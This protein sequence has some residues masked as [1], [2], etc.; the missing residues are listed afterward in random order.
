MEGYKW[1][2]GRIKERL[3]D[4]RRRGEKEIGVQGLRGLDSW[5]PISSFLLYYDDYEF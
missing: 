5:H 2:L 4:E 1:D 3:F